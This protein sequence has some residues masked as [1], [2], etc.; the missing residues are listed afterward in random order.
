MSDA[1]WLPVEAPAAGARLHAPAT[2]RNRRAI[3]DVLAA[4]LPTAGIV[5]EVASGSGEHAVYFA[6]R[7]PTLDWQPS[8]A[9]PAALASIAAWRSDA[10][11]ANLR[12]ALKL[13]A[14][15]DWPMLAVDA[16]VCI[17][18]LHISPWEATEGLMRGAARSMP[19]GA[20]L[21][22][23]GPFLE[24]EVETAT[25]NLAFDASLR[26]RDRAWGLRSLEDVRRLSESHGLALRERVALPANNLALVFRSDV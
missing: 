24:G 7:F 17:N 16:V 23:Y 14:A 9:D 8:D 3:A 21:V 4:A 26:R 20:P 6:G 13:D 12:P 15:G 25:S 5:L 10:G 22:V 11:L 2:A 18:M 19:R 1:P